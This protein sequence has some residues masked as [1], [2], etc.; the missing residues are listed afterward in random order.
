MSAPSLLGVSV[1]LLLLGSLA[2]LLLAR[3]RR[4][5]GW[6]SVGFVAGAAVPLW[7]LVVRTFSAGPDPEWVLLRLPALGAGLVVGVDRLSALFLAITGSIAFLTTLY[8]VEDMARYPRDGV[9]KYYPLLQLL[10]VGIVGVVS[11]ADLLFFL[12]FWELMTFASFF[13]VAFEGE[14][15]VSQRAGLKYFVVNQAAALGMLAAA[16]VLWSR[17]GSFRFSALREALSGLLASEPLLAHLVI[18]LFFVGFA[19]KAG[20]LPMG[21]W[22][23]DAYPAAPSAATAAFGGTMTKLGIYGLLRVFLGFVPVS[24][25]SEAWG[26]VIGLAGL[27]SL[28]VGTLTALKQDDAKRLMSFHVI[29]QVGYMFLGVGLGLFFLRSNPTLAALGLMAGVFHMLNH[30]LYKTCLFLGA[31]AVA[32]RTGSRSLNALGGLGP[33]MPITAACALLAALA[34]A[35]VPPLNGFASKWLLYLAAILGGLGFPLFAVAGIVAMFV[36]LATL[37]SF[38]KYLGGTF[39][40][41]PSTREGLREVPAV[42]LVPQAALALSCLA[43]G[44]WPAW[45]LRFVHRA[46][47]DLAPRAGLPDLVALLGPGPGLAASVGALGVAAWA[48]LALVAG[49]AVLAA[50]AVVIQHAGG[51]AVRRVTVWNCGEEHAVESVRYPASSFYQPLKHAFHG[52]YPTFALHPPAFPGWLR[53]ALDVDAWLLLPLA[54]DV[55]RAARGVSR[56]HVGVP[57]VYLLWIVV[58]AVVVV[59]ILL[60][61]G[62]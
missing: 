23:P 39:L 62:L 38:L 1:L 28:V 9:A 43:F 15:R 33:F 49:I 60:A 16:L 12:V 29:G 20:I 55:E 14:S 57:Q 50:L 32:Y 24:R 31:G 58:G 6:A 61:L 59:G 27:A 47:V 13:L 7:I 44:L 30:A 53:R 51:A 40:G 19:T 10:F 35:G 37:A 36:S 22:L 3:D 11:T 41:P 42:M 52:I 45:P 46:L 21:D 56:T 54:R 26:L 48:P 17:S 25:A 4:A 5:S 34:I 18:L 8:S 2:S